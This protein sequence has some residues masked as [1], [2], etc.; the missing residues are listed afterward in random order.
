MSF[1]FVTQV[2]AEIARTLLRQSV[3]VGGLRL[4]VGLDLRQSFDERLRKIEHARENLTDALSAM[5]ELQAQ[6]EENMRALN[7][8]NRAIDGAAQEKD[9]VS[10]ELKTVRTLA[11]LDT[12][13]VR[14]ALGVPTRAKI[15][16]DRAIAFVLGIAASLIA[17]WLWV[18]LFA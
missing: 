7:E 16:A 13:T 3:T 5:D 1:E 11:E 12:E 14:R 2:V 17:T 18:L 6:V 4:S 15:W 8:L 10:Q 9:A